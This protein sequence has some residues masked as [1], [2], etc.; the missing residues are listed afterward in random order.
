M[1][2]TKIEVKEDLTFKEV[3]AICQEIILNENAR[4]GNMN[5]DVPLFKGSKKDY[6]SFINQYGKVEYWRQVYDE[7]KADNI[8]FSD[9]GIYA[10]AVLFNFC[11]YC[12]MQEGRHLTGIPMDYLLTAGIDSILYYLKDFDPYK[13]A[14]STYFMTY[15]NQET[16]DEIQNN[17]D[18][19]TKY[20]SAK[21]I[22]Y[23]KIAKEWGYEGFLDP[24]LKPILIANKTGDSLKTVLSTR[25]VMQNSQGSIASLSATS[26]N[27]EAEQDIFILPEQAVLQKEQQAFLREK[28]GKLTTLEQFIILKTDWSDEPISNRKLIAEINSNIELFRDEIPRGKVDGNFINAIKH[29]G[30]A[31]L[32]ENK[33]VLNYMSKNV[34]HAIEVEEAEQCTIS[35]IENAIIA[36]LGDI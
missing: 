29:R 26:E 35:D 28:V 30:R 6:S 31:K 7:W 2:R 24:N 19:P 5:C 4:M 13:A 9:Y 22:K 23:D 10:C 18:S 12:T 3:L 8:S 32:R 15:I 33:S 11:K 14:P 21:S 20:Y 27:F 34:S 17:T 16:G 36:S 1:G 25:E